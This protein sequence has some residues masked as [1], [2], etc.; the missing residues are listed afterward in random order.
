M[1]NLQ[2]FHKMKWVNE[3]GEESE[4]VKIYGIFAILIEMLNKQELYIQEID[5][6]LAKINEKLKPIK[7]R[8]IVKK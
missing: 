2:V 6:Q 3:K 1:L 4:Q 5:R 7:E 8:E